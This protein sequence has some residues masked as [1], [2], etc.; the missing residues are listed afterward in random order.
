MCTWMV[1]LFRRIERDLLEIKPQTSFRLACR[2]P[3]SKTGGRIYK[4][5][6]WQHCGLSGA[7]SIDIQVTHPTHQ[8]NCDRIISASNEACADSTFT[9]LKLSPAGFKI[10]APRTSSHITRLSSGPEC[11]PV[12]HSTLTVTRILN[13][14]IVENSLIHSAT[15]PIATVTIKRPATLPFINPRTRPDATLKNTRKLCKRKTVVSFSTPSHSS[16]C[17]SS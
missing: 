3:P 12:G 13:I 16:P 2:T 9:P 15:S 10:S 17:Q 4:P 5:R 1:M 7:R 8:T 14:M 11:S 6:A